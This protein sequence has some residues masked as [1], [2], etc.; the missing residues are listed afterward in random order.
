[1]SKLDCPYVRRET[2]YWIYSTMQY[3]GYSCSICHE[4]YNEEEYQRV[5]RFRFCPQCGS[6]MI[7][8]REEVT[9]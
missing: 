7:E 4:K 3:R 9:K 6:K 5:W 1:M 2:G 8:V